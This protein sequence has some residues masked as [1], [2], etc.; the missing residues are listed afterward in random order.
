MVSVCVLVVVVL[1]LVERNAQ[2][3]ARLEGEAR[4]DALTGLFNRRGFD[5]RA[6]LE[7]LRARRETTSIAVVAFDIDY[8]KRVN[9]EWGHETGD[10]VLARTG[11]LLARAARDIDVVARFGGEE[12]VAL[13]PGCHDRQAEAFAERMRASLANDSDSG[14][15]AVRLSAGVAAQIAPA[16]VDDM[17]HAADDALYQAKRGGRDRTVVLRDRAARMHAAPV[18]PGAELSLPA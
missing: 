1:T 2:L 18:D 9:D 8:F 4:T 13:L 11:E 15:P 6:G 16:S 3:L 12:F 17:L 14:L 7:L 10:R 5:E